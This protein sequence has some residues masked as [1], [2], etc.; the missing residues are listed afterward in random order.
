MATSGRS[1]ISTE[2]APS[3]I[4]P[5]SQA[6]DIDGWVYCSGQI[7]IV[8][9]DGSVVLGIEQQ[10]KQVLINLG[11]VLSAAGCDF[12]D[13]VK[14]TVYLS[15]MGN[16]VAMNEEYAQ[17]FTEPFP[18]RACIEAAALPKGVRVEIDAIARK[19]DNN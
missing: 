17:F 7:P 1:A 2:G 14:T 15:D 3:A 13:V 12:S 18:A 19:R 5:Y 8:P 11:E 9:Q 16:F 10:T 6:I 4:G